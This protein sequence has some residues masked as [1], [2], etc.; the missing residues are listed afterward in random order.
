MHFKQIVN[1][2]TAIYD[3]REASSIVKMLLEE[4]FGLSFVDVCLGALDR[5]SDDDKESLEGMMLRLEKG[6]P[7]QYV[8]GRADF[9]GRPFAVEPGVLIPRPETEELV[10][11]ILEEN[12]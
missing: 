5:L 4:S 7:V 11:W 12:S 8:I 6:E 9:Y 3:E 10:S 1:R 2:L